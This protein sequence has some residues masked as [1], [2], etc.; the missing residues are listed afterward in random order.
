MKIVFLFTAAKKLL[1]HVCITL[2]T[3]IF[4]K[5]LSLEKQEEL[6]ILLVKN[7]IENSKT[8]FDDGLFNTLFDGTKFKIIT[9]K[10]E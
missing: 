1:K 9:E 7:Y 8:K 6:L 2:V 10:E 3:N 4:K 5:H